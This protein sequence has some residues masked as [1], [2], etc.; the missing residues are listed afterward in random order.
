MKQTMSKF[1]QASIVCAALAALF[2]AGSVAYA[3]WS[4]PTATPPNNN[5]EVPLNTGASTQTKQGDLY[6]KNTYPVIGMSDTSIA[7]GDQW[8][9]ITNS[10]SDYSYYYFRF[11]RD[12]NGAN[13]ASASGDGNQYP[14]L[15]RAGN[16]LNGDN[17]YARFSN[18]VRADRFCDYSGGNCFSPNEVESAPAVSCRSINRFRTESK[19]FL[20]ASNSRINC[21][22]GDFPCMARYCDS[23]YGTS[24]WAGQEAACSGGICVFSCIRPVPVTVCAAGL[25]VSY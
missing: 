20:P 16:N 14:F 8:W 19:P 2:I 7:D 10:N 1:A 24:A 22:W 15:L 4:N 6:I 21:S 18:Q 5:A 23:R 13:Q 3:Q 25:T 12:G 17:D 11:D 9:M